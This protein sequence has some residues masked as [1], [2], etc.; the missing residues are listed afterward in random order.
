MCTNKKGYI[1]VYQNKILSLQKLFLR[2]ALKKNYL[3]IAISILNIM[4]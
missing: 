3:L 2:N 4:I 1:S